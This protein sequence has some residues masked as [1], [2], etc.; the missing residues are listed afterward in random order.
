MI[1]TLRRPWQ[2][3][4][5]RRPAPGTAPGTPAGSHVRFKSN[6]ELP[7]AAEGLESPD[8]PDA[9]YRNKRATQGTGSMIHVSEPCEPPAPHVLTHVHTTP[10]TVHEAPCTTP[11]QQ[12]LV[13]TDMP[14]REHLV[15]A[16]YSAAEVLVDSREEHGIIWRG[17]T[18]PSPGWQAQVEGA[19]TINQ[20]TVD[21]DRQGVTCPQGKCSA[22][23]AAPVDRQ[24]D[25][26]G[27]LVAF[28]TQ[29]WTACVARSRC[30]RAESTG[31]RLHLPPQEQY[32]A[33][34]AAR[35]W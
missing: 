8:A 32:E 3:H 6:K 25:R 4:D 28:R 29:D 7:R 24:R 16:A 10:A 23:W 20:F 21:W 27:I 31:R 14:P 13:D 18:R 17:P 26:P 12:A 34:Q 33:L 15:D 11:I 5:E 9:R 2:R 22:M 30:T 35:T 19:Y 1:E